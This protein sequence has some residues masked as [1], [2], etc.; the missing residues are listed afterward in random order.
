MSQGQTLDTGGS[1]SGSCVE[2]PGE[3]LPGRSGRWA[4]VIPGRHIAGSLG[5]GMGIVKPVVSN[6]VIRTPE[7]RL[8]S[9][10]LLRLGMRH[11]GGGFLER[12]TLPGAIQVVPGH[13]GWTTVLF[14]SPLYRDSRVTQVYARLFWDHQGMLGHSRCECVDV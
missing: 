3:A 2:L 12:A 8:V 10:V 9:G 5:H 11:E 13:T 6:W 1:P 4:G 14:L 7:A